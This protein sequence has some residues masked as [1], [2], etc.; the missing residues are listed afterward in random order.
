MKLNLFHPHDSRHRVRALTRGER[1]INLLVFVGV[2]PFIGGFAYVI[3]HAFKDVS[4]ILAYFPIA[5]AV[6]YLVGVIPALIC[7][8]L[9]QVYLHFAQARSITR[10]ILFGALT[11]ILAIVVVMLFSLIVNLDNLKQLE[12][13]I[14]EGLKAGVFAMLAG[15][16]AG[17][18]TKRPTLT[19]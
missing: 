19:E 1:I 16:I 11:G 4:T 2:G 10:D 8:L 5:L 14:S 13:M 3:L 6:T 18:L 17:L 7:N 12:K 15:G 9:F